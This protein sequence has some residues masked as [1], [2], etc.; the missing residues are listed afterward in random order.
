[1][2]GFFGAV[3]VLAIA[4]KKKYSHININTP[5]KFTVTTEENKP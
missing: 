4:G 1:M 2:Y 3:L 5:S